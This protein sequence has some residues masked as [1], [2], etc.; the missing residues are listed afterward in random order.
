MIPK[1]LVNGIVFGYRV[2]VWKESEGP[3]SKWSVT[4][5]PTNLTLEIPELEKYTRYCGQ[6]EAFTRVG[7]GPRSLVECTRTFEDG[8]L[9]GAVH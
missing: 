9:Y 8:K 7:A 3:A 1:H 5:P 4:V 2:F 6:M